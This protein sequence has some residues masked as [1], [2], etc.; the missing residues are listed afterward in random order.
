[1]ECKK[2]EFTA[3][4]YL[5]RELDEKESRDYREHLAIC[6]ACRARLAEIER[7]S[8]ALKT[9]APPVMPRELHRDIMNAVERQVAGPANFGQYV[10]EWLLRLNPRPLAY[11]TGVMASLLLFGFVLSGVRPI[12]TSRSV[13]VQAVVF[14][15]VTGSEGEFKSYNDLATD[16]NQAGRNDYYQLP[17]VLNNGALVS[18]SKVAYQKP[19]PNGMAAL[20]EIST[21][22]HAEIVDVLDEQSDP[23]MVEQLWWS[24]GHPT[25]QPALVE[26]RPVPTR[27]VL[28]VEKVDVSG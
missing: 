24:L 8:L 11:V 14:P 4:A 16:P 7:V 5:D 25:F 9:A 1:M 17:R 3:S 20:V 19:G 26:G 6:P 2:F 23:E 13:A 22:G 12:P 10:S 21:D 15:V 18:F 27:I 28:L